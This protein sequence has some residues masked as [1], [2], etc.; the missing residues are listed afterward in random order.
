MIQT[1]FILIEYIYFFIIALCIPKL[2]YE[3]ILT[4]KRNVAW[5]RNN[6]QTNTY[7][8]RTSLDALWPVPVDDNCVK[9]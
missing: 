2:V 1:S 4:G 3:H 6:G 9:W 7:L 8:G 5:P